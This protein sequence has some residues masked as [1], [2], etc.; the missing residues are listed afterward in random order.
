MIG[1]LQV[2]R[3]LALI[4]AVTSIA[5]PLLLDAAHSAE[6]STSQE[7]TTKNAQGES[8][9]EL[10]TVTVQATRERELKFRPRCRFGTECAASAC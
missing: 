6:V 2:G 7:A 1:T 9:R 3:L 10:D 4:A 8:R 5:L